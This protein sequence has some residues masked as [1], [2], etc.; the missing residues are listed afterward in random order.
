MTTSYTSDT[1]RL[2]MV[3]G[4]PY[5]R[6]Q[7]RKPEPDITLVQSLIA[8]AVLAVFELVVLAVAVGVS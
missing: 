3:N 5:A 4:A 7:N 6:E 2:F 8:G 1:R